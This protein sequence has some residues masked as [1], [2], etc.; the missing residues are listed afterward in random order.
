MPRTLTPVEK[1]REQERLR[2]ESARE[3]VAKARE[4]KRRN[5]EAGYPKDTV[6]D[7]IPEGDDSAE[8]NEDSKENNGN[9]EEE[10]NNG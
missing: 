1:G 5:V 8:D 4:R 7:V 2:R 3:Q 10:N 6:G 9:T